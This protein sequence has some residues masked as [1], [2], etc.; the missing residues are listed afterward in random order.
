MAKNIIKE[1]FLNKNIFSTKSQVSTK[2]QVSSVDLLVSI[3]LFLMIFFALRGIW[4]NGTSTL[5]SD[6]ETFNMRTNANNAINVLLNTSGY[7]KNW[8]VQNV[9]LIGLAKKSFILEEQKVDLFSQMDYETAREKMGLGGYDFYFDLNSK[10]P[11]ERIF[12]GKNIDSN[13]KVYSTNRT[14]VYKGGEASVVFA[15]FTN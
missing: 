13:T 2:G 10:Y 8:T 12:I 3:L 7:P 5:L 14:V 11:H 9:E 6:Y 4:V 15:V 1:N